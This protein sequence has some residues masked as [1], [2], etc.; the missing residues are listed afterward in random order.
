VAGS[1]SRIGKSVGRKVS[2]SFLLN[3]IDSIRLQEGQILIITTNHITRLDKALIRPGR[4]DK[5]VEL[6]LANNKI[7]ANLFYLVF[8][9]VEGDVTLLKDARIK[10]LAI[11]F[12]IKVPELKF[13]LVE[14]FS[15]LLEYRKS[16]EEA[17]NNVD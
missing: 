8:K 1:P 2:L 4:V 10:Q 5:K 11:E 7:T 17:I 6:G 14:I 9:R 16:L 15:F 13:S 12:A 3:V